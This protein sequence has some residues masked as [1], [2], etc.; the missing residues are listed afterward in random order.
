MA[1]TP[2]GGGGSGIEISRLILAVDAE[3]GIGQVDKLDASLKGLGETAEVAG[4]K[5]GTIST[6]A[7]PSLEAIGVAA[8]AAEAGLKNLN[9][10]VKDLE[11]AE[12]QAIAIQEA[13]SDQA[14]AFILKLQRL[15]D[16]FGMTKT[17]LLLFTAAEIAAGDAAIKLIGELDLLEAATKRYGVVIQNVAGIEAARIAFEESALTAFTAF[18]TRTIAENAAMEES[19]ATALNAQRIRSITENLAAEQSAATALNAQR[20]RSIA[21]NLAEEES[22]ATVF[23]AF[24]AR[25]LAENASAE[26]SAATVLNAQRIRSIS[27]QQTFEESAATAF[28]A[29][30]NRV[31]AENATAEESATIAL[32]AQRIRSI[33]ENLAEEQSASTAFAAFKSRTLAEN[34]AAE[35]SAQTVLM[36]FKARTIAENLAAEESASTALNAQ[37]IRSI[38]ENLAR[39]ESASTALN[40]QRNRSISE[41][42]AK[43]QS[44]SAALNAQRN[45]SLVENLAKEQSAAT[46]LQAFKTRTQAENAAALQ[47]Q[48][49][50]ARAAAIALAEKQAIEEIKWNAMSVKARI[51]ELERLKLY[52]ANSAITPATITTTFSSAT[53]ADLPN[54][55][56]YKQQI[57][58]LVPAT[59]AVQSGF[60]GIGRSV[61][62]MLAGAGI[63]LGLHQ[64]ITLTDQYTKFTAQLK[65]ATSSNREYSV[66][67]ADVQRISKIS[68]SDIGSTGVLYA[69]IANSVRELGM[70]QTQV[71]KITETI[72]LAMKVSGATAQEYKSAMLQLS[73][74]FA[75]GQL[76]GEEFN[77]VNE[78]APRLMK[79]LADGMGVPIAA[80][81]E[82][83]T[84]GKLTT[85]VMGV[86]I[87]KALET[88]R[89]ESEHVRTI[90]G[91]FTVLNNAIMMFVGTQAHA[92]GAVRVTNNVIVKLSEN[93]TLLAG[94]SATL[95][96]VGI[97]KWLT[98]IYIATKTNIAA[99]GVLLASNLA[100]ATSQVTAT[101]AAAALATAQVA[102]LRASILAAQGNA[103]LTASLAAMLV[104]AELA[105]TVATDAHIAA[106][107]LEAN[108]LRA[109]TVLARIKA[110]SLL[111]LGGPI[112]WITL[113]VGLGATAWM[114]WGNSVEE[115]NKKA[116]EAVEMSTREM[117]ANFDVQIEK[118]RERLVLLKAGNIELARDGGPNAEKL[119]S[120]L[121]KINELKAKGTARTGTDEIE[122]IEL[123]GE[124]FKLI[125]QLETVKNLNGQI[126]DVGFAEKA[127]EWALKYSTNL[128]KMN[129]E[130]AKYKK[131]SGTAYD[132]KIEKAIRDQF[133]EK[134][135]K[136]HDNS[137]TSLEKE[138]IAQER[139]IKGKE[140]QLKANDIFVLSELRVNEAQVLSDLN[141]G[142]YEDSFKRLSKA[143][144]DALVV[145]LK[146]NAVRK[147]DLLIQE[148]EM[149]NLKELIDGIYKLSNAETKQIEDAIAKQKEHNWSIGK[150][151][152][153][154]DLRQAAQQEAATQEIQTTIEVI[155][156]L[157]EKQ[158]VNIE[159]ALVDVK[160]DAQA[161]AIYEA[162]LVR[163]KNLRAA[164]NELRDV[165]LAGASLEGT[166]AAQKEADRLWEQTNKKIGDD[167]ASA[168]VDGGGKGWKKLIRDM[169]LAFAKMILQPIL[170]PIS[171]GFASFMSP[172]ATQAGGFAGA[173]QAGSNT[174]S[175]ASN[176]YSLYNNAAFAG[177]ALFGSG[178][179][180][181][182]SWMAGTSAVAPTTVA[183]ANIAGAVGGDAI[184]VLTSSYSGAAAAAPA[185]TGIGA[186]ISTTL[187]AIP[188]W[189]WAAMAAIAVVSIFGGGGKKEMKAQGI[190]G[191]FGG[192]SFSGNGFVDSKKDGG[193]FH[194]DKKYHET[195]QLDLGFIRQ[196]SE[197]YAGIKKSSTEYG[198]AL[199][200]NTSSIDTYTQRISVSLTKAEIKGKTPE[201]INKLLME[202]INKVFSD[203]ADTMAKSVIPDISAYSKAGESASAT[204]QRLA[205]SLTSVNA[206]FDMLEVTL[207]QTS[208][209]G[210]DMASKLID[211][212]GGAQNMQ[213]LSGAYFQNFY[214]EAE[215]VKIGTRQLTKEFTDLG[216]GALPT[217]HE[218]LRGWIETLDLTTQSGREQYVKMLQLAGAY[219]TLTE[220]QKQ[221]LESTENSIGKAKEA[222]SAAYDKESTALQN[223]IDRLKAF[224]QEL[225][226]FKDGLL[227]NE[228]S[229][230]TPEQKYAEA[231]RQYEKTLQLAAGGDED[232]QGRLTETA[233]AFLEASRIVNAS[234]AQYLSD[235]ARVQKSLDEAQTWITTQVDI[236]TASLAAL[237]LQVKGL[238]EVK[239]AV[240]S[241][242]EAINN[243]TVAMGGTP[244]PMPSVSI[245]GSHALGLAR[246]PFDGYIAK[247][248]K[249]ERVL[250]ST[251]AIN[252]GSMGRLDMA[253]LAAE[254]KALRAEVAMLRADQK[255]QT[256]AVIAS[257]Y[258]ANDR[259]A[260]KVAAS[261]KDAA[262]DV[263]WADKSKAQVI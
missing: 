51:A 256:G 186:G 216:Y 244:L 57:D 130:I 100:L 1:D 58:D 99:N 36:A 211:A 191:N 205:I 209:M 219:H 142:R 250:T 183:A 154:I 76:R 34:I 181:V 64:L 16:T 59:Q 46:V 15:V 56:G 63:T 193:W 40:A 132:P 18:K 217:S 227:L 42:L 229:P 168:I 115:A 75:S 25:S 73:Q 120:M 128:E 144:A 214:D 107:L 137:I 2:S 98:G 22:A 200:L 185:A 106:Q 72:A 228:M 85:E 171:G 242:T 117:S 147:D 11:E 215:R 20:T 96:A 170:A 44:A 6:K 158:Q 108:A 172:G 195:S 194:R 226:V 248:H 238:I 138:V 123:Q 3:L 124:Y 4:T 187:A 37:R 182:A 260:N 69:R 189:G 163:L 83:A 27:E 133:A 67:I 263:V 161:R 131:E 202:K 79:A 7:V 111:L 103:T 167:L 176:A 65:L 208:V 9:R 143:K 258:D 121:K 157:L 252:Y 45:R 28:R 127:A 48:R 155:D 152:E 257:N 97:V 253:P 125:K 116:T 118:L 55:D 151:K 14:I 12:S 104:P 179:G 5:L 87:P 122:L 190:E 47:A 222:L 50:S 237:D 88:V 92:S 139:W 246:V 17:E 54:L 240:L 71:A 89:K 145:N 173:A 254:I 218:Q 113:L 105:A 198:E 177:N 119:G 204:F 207:Y 41:N 243:L 166:F 68:Q 174:L 233:N 24:K 102:S 109:T 245:D 129:V 169:K 70:G 62:N 148:L 10:A 29:F 101:G 150:T 262:K 223:T 140:A 49:E 93:L 236:A 180:T 13:L 33:S 203:M 197:T 220:A 60:D 210:A 26:E 165:N 212:F 249:D 78:A 43:E 232:A 206:M 192:D 110:A 201:E 164:R 159:G 39:E 162:E 135:K 21:E 134:N 178:S 241:V 160:L 255:E 35:E 8:K 149:K 199:G 126:A 84:Q 90:G 156:M 224:G 91:A 66:A 146:A 38:A 80:L 225:R 94:V 188:V 184:G 19:S 31:L 261:T 153:Q 221:A 53:I 32:N 196:L 213:S 112:G 30:K 95:V 114:V 136:Q 23:R 175:M 235:F 141:T 82:M 61:R 230:L 74:A 239:V 81:R 52:Q 259:A 247:L 251:E 86:A 234:D 231:T 77:A